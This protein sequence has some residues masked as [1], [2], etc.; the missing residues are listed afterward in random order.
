M[1][2]KKVISMNELRFRVDFILPKDE[3]QRVSYRIGDDG[4]T[5][6]ILDLHGLRCNEARRLI[7][8][9]VNILRQRITVILIHGYNHGTAIRDMLPTIHNEHIAGL[10]RD[11]YNQGKTYLYCA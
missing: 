9:L 2:M 5:E 7:V 6:I 8:N 10:R 4:Q 1:M 3:K 11:T